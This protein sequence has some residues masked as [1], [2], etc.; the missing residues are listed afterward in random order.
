MR[1]AIMS[2]RPVLKNDV[3]RERKYLAACKIWDE[4]DP[5]DGSVADVYLTGIGVRL[6]TCTAHFLRFHPAVLH[7]PTRVYYP[8]LLAA[9]RLPASM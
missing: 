6:S 7:E 9:V 2:A 4:S 5:I 1:A 3:S 8:T